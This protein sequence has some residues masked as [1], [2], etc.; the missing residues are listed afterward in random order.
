[1]WQVPPRS[2]QAGAARGPTRRPRRRRG[3]IPIDGLSCR[4]SDGI[5]DNTPKGPHNAPGAGRSPYGA[6]RRR[7]IAGVARLAPPPAERMK[8]M[9]EQPPRDAGPGGDPYSRVDY[10]RLIAWPKRLESEAP[11]L[12][13]ILERAPKRAV[14]DVGCGTGEHSRFLAGEG[15][16]VVGLDLSES[17]LAKARETPLPPNLSFILGNVTRLGE[18]IDGTFGA[19]ISLG[20]TLVHLQS[21]EEWRAALDGL[22]RRLEPGGLFAF[23]ILNYERI[24]ARGIRHLPL[25]FRENGDEEIVF[26]RLLDLFDDGRVRFC[27]TAL[28]YKRGTDPPVELV[29]SQAVDI[30]GWKREELLPL[31]EEAGFR[32]MELHGDMKSGPYDPMESSDLVVVAERTK[33]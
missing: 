21:R 22:H 25:S 31:L 17:M 3:A 11:F 19:A 30:R 24:F 18:L 1:M 12:R 4:T 16:E 9:Q 23:Q 6:A 15:F 27:P 14:I 33:A 26:L 13:R 5:M 29:R 32:V 2:L 20:N 8:T 7:W 10:R 28:R